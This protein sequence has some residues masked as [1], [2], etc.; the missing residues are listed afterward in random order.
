MNTNNINWNDG[1]MITENR[2]TD[3][4]GIICHLRWMNEM[5][6]S[7]S[8]TTMKKIWCAFKNGHPICDWTEQRHKINLTQIH[9]SIL[10]SKKRIL[11]LAWRNGKK[12]SPNVFGLIC[13][14]I[15]IYIRLSIHYYY[16]CCYHKTVC[17][18][19]RRQLYQ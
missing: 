9:C 7:T 4:E 15:C 11:S 3:K 18:Y 19:V 12:K 10:Y 14:A 8:V 13:Y 2:Q 5:F 17:A 16:Y 1:N 6:D